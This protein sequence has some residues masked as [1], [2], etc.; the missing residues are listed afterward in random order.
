MKQRLAGLAL[1][2]L[3]SGCSA[4]DWLTTLTSSNIY[5]DQDGI[6][7]VIFDPSATYISDVE[8][9]SKQILDTTF[10]GYWMPDTADVLALE[11]ALP[12]YLDQQAAAGRD[13]EGVAAKLPDYKRQYIGFIAGGEKML[14]ANYFC[15]AFDDDRWLHDW[16]Y[17]MDGGNCFFQVVYQVSSGEFRYLSINGYA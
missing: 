11:S 13:V 17:V 12:A 16:L 10:D 9:I 6:A 15:D 3:L 14:Y 7:G 5:I 8:S 4:L 1:L 2:L